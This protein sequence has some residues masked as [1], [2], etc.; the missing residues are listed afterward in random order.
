LI[1]GGAWIGLL[2]FALIGMV[3]MQLL[4][5]KLNTGIGH[6]LTRVAQLQREN[7]QLG[8]EDS[9]ASAESRVAPL[10]VSAGMTLAPVGTVHFVAASPAYV[11]RAA[12]AL[13][14]PVQPPPGSEST[15]APSAESEATGTEVATGSPSSTSST[16]AT[17]EPGAPSESS[18]SV[19]GEPQGSTATTAE[20]GG[21]TES[22]TAT[23]GRRE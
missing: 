5:L 17:G 12:T 19:A 13:S 9:A 4:V 10:A 23:S 2:A 14:S 18:S 16:A 1:R 8:I 20:A 6:T 21:S 11:A 7:A 15:Q 22:S 3:A